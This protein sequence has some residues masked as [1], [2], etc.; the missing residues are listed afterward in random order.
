MPQNGRRSITRGCVSKVYI[1][2][3]T[4]WLNWSAVP[5][6][7]VTKSSSYRYVSHPLPSYQLWWCW[8][9]GRLKRQYTCISPRGIT[10]QITIVFILTAVINCNLTHKR[11]N[12]NKMEEDVHMYR[13]WGDGI[14][15]RRCWGFLRDICRKS[16]S[17][18]LTCETL[19]APRNIHSS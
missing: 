12:V 2:G 6:S 15:Y 10:S 18:R 17:S 16:V 9:Q 7:C 19:S 14:F 13:T 5:D 8:Q 4:V 1:V 3:Y 11:K